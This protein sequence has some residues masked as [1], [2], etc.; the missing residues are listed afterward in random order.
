MEGG[1]NF[2]KRKKIHTFN[3]I[4][5]QDVDYNENC[6]QNIWYEKRTSPLEGIIT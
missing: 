1:Y 4:G 3:F 2:K 6:I 5:V